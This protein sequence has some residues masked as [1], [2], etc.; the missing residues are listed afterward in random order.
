MQYPKPGAQHG[1]F[2]VLPIKRK[3]NPECVHHSQHHLQHQG[4]KHK[5]EHP[6]VPTAAAPQGHGQEHTQANVRDQ[7]EA[8]GGFSSCGQTVSGSSKGRVLRNDTGHRAA[9]KI[10][11]IEPG[12]TKHP[13]QGPA[14][15]AAPDSARARRVTRR[16]IKA[17][18]AAVGVVCHANVQ[19]GVS[20]TA[21]LCSPHEVAGNGPQ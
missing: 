20:G 16:V 1:G 21:S 12:V 14:P 6:S 18:F 8:L 19:P 11:Q 2:V 9:D 17:C 15:A 4:G 3:N 10:G 5:A 13:R 7:C